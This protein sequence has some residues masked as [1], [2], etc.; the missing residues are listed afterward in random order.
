MKTKCLTAVLSALALTSAL[1]GTASAEH[2]SREEVRRNLYNGGWSIAWG[3][4]ITEKEYAETAAALGVSVYTGQAEVAI[5]YAKYL[6]RINY[7]KMRGQLPGVGRELFV[8]WV[9]QSIQKGTPLVYRGVELDAGFATYRR[10]ERVVYHE[11]QTKTHWVKAGPFKTKVF[12][13]EMVKKER[14]I[15]WP[16]HHQPY[17]RLRP[18]R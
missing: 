4:T 15:P 14:I 1:Q 16:N 10:W 12:K 11:P 8:N 9:V 7:E 3:H 6:A 18:V 5:E 17:I 2:T 13:V